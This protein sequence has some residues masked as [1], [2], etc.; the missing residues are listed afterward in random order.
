[1]QILRGLMIMAAVTA[2][3]A[4][5]FNK[6]EEVDALNEAQAVGSPFTQKLTSEYRDF[7]NDE[8]DSMGD[9]ADGLHFARKGLASAR[10]DVV[11]PEPLA[12]WNIK[13]EYMN[14]LSLGRSRLVAVYDLGAREAYPDVSAV[15]QARYDC[16][17]ENQEEDFQPDEINRCKREFL[18]ALEQ[19]EGAMPAAAPPSA[20]AP[21]AEPAFNVD[22]NA[23]MEV[24]NAMYLVFFDW[25]QSTLGPGAQSVLDAVAAEV[26][27][28]SLTAVNVVGHADT[29]GPTDYNQK[30]AQRRANAVRDALIQRG[31]SA[32]LINGS[33]RGE[34]ELLVATPDNV[35]EPANR[36]AQISFQ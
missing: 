8:V 13:S 32:N 11:M 5:D 7:V 22:P 35:R 14:E 28:R 4:C 1:M 19:L 27:K 31:V 2:L 25:D 26:S 17:I 30:L 12:D 29:S 36:R 20:P 16:W 3:T 23:P 9:H 21:V 18:A 34:N 24:E 15:A 6:F 10:G 33:S